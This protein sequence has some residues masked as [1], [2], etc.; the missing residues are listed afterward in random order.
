MAGRH[1]FV[2]KDLAIAIRPESGGGSGGTWMPAEDGTELPW[3]LSPI[4]A[5]TVK[6]HVLESVGRIISETLESKGELDGIVQAFDRGPDANPAIAAVIHEVGAAVVAGAAYARIG[7]SVG[8][9]DPNCAGS[10]TETIPPTITP[11][12]HKGLEVHRVSELPKLRRQMEIAVETLDR[13]SAE[14]KPQ[15]GEA[16]MVAKKLEEAQKELGG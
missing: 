8:Y 1:E 6:G 4:A 11:I 14:L 10:S 9:P 5:V 15:R 3:W 16:K 7:S 12:V 2:I 13:L